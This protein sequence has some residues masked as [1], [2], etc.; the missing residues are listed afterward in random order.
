[1]PLSRDQLRKELHKLDQLSP[2]QCADILPKLL[3]DEFRYFY[4]RQYYAAV[5]EKILQPSFFSQLSNEMKAILYLKILNTFI[6]SHDVEKLKVFLKNSIFS[7]AD[8][9]KKVFEVLNSVAHALCAYKLSEFAEAE[10]HFAMAQLNVCDVSHSSTQNKLNALIEKE[11]GLCCLDRHAYQVR[12]SLNNIVD[13]QLDQSITINQDFLLSAKEHFK[14][15]ANFA[16]TGP[17]YLQAQHYIL[18]CNTKLFRFS[19]GVDAALL[20]EIIDDINSDQN[21][22]FLD[23]V[24]CDPKFSNLDY[25]L[26]LQYTADAYL[27]LEHFDRAIEKLELASLFCTQ[28][29]QKGIKAALGAAYLSAKRYEDAELNLLAARTEY[30]TLDRNEPGKFAVSLRKIEAKLLQLKRERNTLNNKTPAPPLK[31]NRRPS[32]FVAAP[33]GSGASPKP[34]GDFYGVVPQQSR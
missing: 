28:S 6:N 30:Q 18:H 34:H 1:M 25:P 26:F 31:E 11:Y 9:D 15:A 27:E 21:L 20:Q 32:F 8:P 24:F 7:F 29:G 33:N 17:T 3:T 2:S 5:I 16:K 4:D 10:I 12:E 19:S 14:N 22:I 23:R 13:V